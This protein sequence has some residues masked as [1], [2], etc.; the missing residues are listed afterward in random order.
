MHLQPGIRKRPSSRSGIEAWIPRYREFGY[1]REEAEGVTRIAERLWNRY[2]ARGLT[3][4]SL[5]PG[6]SALE[7]FEVLIQA[8][9]HFDER[10]M[11]DEARPICTRTMR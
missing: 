4:D 7:P 5:N 11:F 3:I 6:P 8:I 1:S 2:T 9:C 10:G